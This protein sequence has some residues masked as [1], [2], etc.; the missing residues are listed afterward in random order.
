[1]SQ[2]NPVETLASALYRALAV[3]LPEIEYEYKKP[4]SNKD[5]KGWATEMRKRRPD[6][7]DVRVFHFMQGWENTAIGLDVSCPWAGQAFTDAYTTVVFEARYGNYAAVYF[8]GRLAYVVPPQGRSNLADD[9]KDSRVVR[10]SR[11]VE[12]YEA[13]L[14]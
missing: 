8:G 10:Q 12:R 6:M 14:P 7:R 1:M 9:I 11:A 5:G 3:D 2:D 4:G 13:V